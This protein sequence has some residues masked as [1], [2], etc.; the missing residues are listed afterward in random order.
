[1][2]TSEII[3]SHRIINDKGLKLAFCLADAQL[4]LNSIA[5]VAEKNMEQDGEFAKIHASNVKSWVEQINARI[6][7]ALEKATKE[8]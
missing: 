7:K 4:E 3:E 5:H 8:G 6:E 1:M 2:K